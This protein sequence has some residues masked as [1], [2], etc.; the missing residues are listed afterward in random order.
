MKPGKEKYS[1]KR[2]ASQREKKGR[3]RRIGG[4]GGSIV[5]W[6][7]AILDPSAAAIFGLFGLKRQV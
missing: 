4:K 2:S 1:S 7:R 6:K 5:A 3:R